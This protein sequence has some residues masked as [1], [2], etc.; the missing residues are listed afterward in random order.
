MLILLEGTD[1]SGKTTIA[2]DL[3]AALSG[4]VILKRNAPTTPPLVE[5]TA[6]LAGYAAGSGQNV[7][8]DRWHLGERVYGPLYRDG[9]GL[10]PIAWAAVEA[11]LYG[12]GALGVLVTASVEH[13][14]VR[15]TRR[16]EKPDL[17]ALSRERVAFERAIT[18]ST[19]KWVTA[20]TASSYSRKAIVSGI[21]KY[22]QL[23][24]DRAANH[25]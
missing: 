23:E 18:W 2:N 7:I 15:L 25:S 17:T 6:D 10:S 21:V 8:C 4:G 11:Y 9:C 16:G 1:G 14:N 3:I 5:Y 24:E 22:A 13:L 19:I 12:L 20:D